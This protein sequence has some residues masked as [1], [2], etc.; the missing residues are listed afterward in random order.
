MRSKTA[1][2]I[3]THN[4]Y[5]T[6]VIRLICHPERS[7]SEVKD[8]E[9]GSQLNKKTTTQESRSGVSNDHDAEKVRSDSYVFN[10]LNLKKA[11]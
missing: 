7:E 9:I 2:S 5:L 8:P 3:Y 10:G 4:T 1:L 11:I 6:T